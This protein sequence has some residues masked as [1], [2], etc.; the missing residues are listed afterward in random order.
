M[1]NQ[2]TDERMLDTLLVVALG[3]LGGSLMGIFVGVRNLS[4][5]I[6]TIAPVGAG[7]MRP[8]LGAQIRRAYESW[9]TLT[10]RPVYVTENPTSQIA[11]NCGPSPLPG[12]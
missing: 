3:F 5:R 12:E 8:L 11:W 4:A 7:L 6:E 9:R 10:I 2:R 1:L